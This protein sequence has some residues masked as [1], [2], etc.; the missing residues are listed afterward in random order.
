MTTLEYGLAILLATQSLAWLI[1]DYQDF[2]PDADTGL[3]D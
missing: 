3:E 1:C 2:D